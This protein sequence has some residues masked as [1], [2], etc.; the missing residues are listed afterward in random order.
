M[1]LARTLRDQGGHFL[2]VVAI[3]GEADPELARWCD[4]LTWVRLGQFK[5]TLAFLKKH[6]VQD[7]VLVGGITKAGIWRAWPDRLALTEFLPRLLNKHD[8]HLLRTVAEI[9]E[10]RGLRVRAVSDFVPGLLAVEGCLSR[11]A[12][13]APEWE[14]IRFGWR[15]AKA[16]G[17]LDI[18]QGVVVRDRVVVAVEAME[19]T[20]AMLQR[21]GT[22]VSGQGGTLV[23][24]CKP[25][26]DRR[27]DIPTVGPRT[28]DHLHRAGLT[29]L[30]IEA[31][32]TMIVELE[33]TLRRADR[34]GIALVACSA[35]SVQ[36]GEGI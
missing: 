29:V 3:R 18:G 8:D 31:G 13:T 35:A 32:Q 25:M 2:A 14:D 10:R 1:I 28:I 23:K 17:E 33:E 4:D 12:P 9:L 21:A 30:A 16:L 27:L 26:Q 6:Q 36:E 5:R 19:G 20:D 7:V 22:L 24:V 34:L 11:H 15:M